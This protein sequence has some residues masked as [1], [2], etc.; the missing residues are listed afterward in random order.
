LRKTLHS[1]PAVHTGCTGLVTALF[2]TDFVRLATFFTDITLLCLDG[3]VQR[4][5][6]LIICY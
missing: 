3:T 2:H 6:N 4:N 5:S 1:K